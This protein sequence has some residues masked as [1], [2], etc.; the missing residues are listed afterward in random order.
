MIGKLCI[1]FLAVLL[2]VPQSYAYIDNSHLFDK[3]SKPKNLLSIL[4]EP[5]IKISMSEA[6]E[7]GKRVIYLSDKAINIANERKVTSS[8]K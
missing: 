5:L 7:S 1:T 3:N 4:N 2:A 8:L 6:L